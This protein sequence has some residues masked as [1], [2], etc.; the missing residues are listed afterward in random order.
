MAV[1]VELILSIFLEL[2]VYVILYVTGAVVVR[3]FSLNRFKPS[4]WYEKN[5]PNKLD[6]FDWFSLCVVVGIFSWAIGVLL[7]WGTLNFS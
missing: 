1:V 3:L 7:I 2:F 6:T 5:T 4:L